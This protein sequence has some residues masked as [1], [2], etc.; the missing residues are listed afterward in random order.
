M[1]TLNIGGA[2]KKDSWGVVSQVPLKIIS[3]VFGNKNGK[4]YDIEYLTK[5]LEVLILILRVLSTL[6]TPGIR[7]RGDTHARRWQQ[8]GT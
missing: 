8:V 2:K 7:A 6:S 5:P 1:E 4:R 3:N